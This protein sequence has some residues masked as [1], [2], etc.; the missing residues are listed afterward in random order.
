MQQLIFDGQPLEDKNLVFDYDIQ[1]ESMVDL[2]LPFHRKFHL[3]APL[4]NWIT[5]SINITI[6]NTKGKTYV[7]RVKGTDTIENVKSRDDPCTVTTIFSLFSHASSA[8]GIV[9]SQGTEQVV[10]K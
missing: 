2:Q 4:P 10:V 1:R 7:I 8:P 3:H 5:G 9:E 6:V